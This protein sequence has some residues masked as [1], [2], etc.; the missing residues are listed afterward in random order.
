FHRHIFP[1]GQLPFSKQVAVSSGGGPSTRIE[2]AALPG[3][4]N[5]AAIYQSVWQ[6]R[7]LTIA[8]AVGAALPLVHIVGDHARGLHRGLAELGVARDL[9][10]DTLAF[11]MEQVAQA[12]E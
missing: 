2:T 7:Q 5:A 10:L 12:L 6:I 8:Q 4:R 11:G 3:I 9:A 1:L